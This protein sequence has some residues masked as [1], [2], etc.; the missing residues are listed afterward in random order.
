MTTFTVHFLM[1]D[2]KTTLTVN[3]L[4]TVHFSVHHIIN[5]DRQNQITLNIQGGLYKIIEFCGYE[6]TL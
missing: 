5:L 1:E 4:E 6:D 3:I 2:I